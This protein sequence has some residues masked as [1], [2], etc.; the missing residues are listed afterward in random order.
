MGQLHFL[1]NRVAHHKPIHRRELAIDAAKIFDLAQWMCLD[2]HAWMT[3]HTRIP[4]VL[5]SK[6]V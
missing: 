5:A 1:R 6:P 2:T 3:G 4:S